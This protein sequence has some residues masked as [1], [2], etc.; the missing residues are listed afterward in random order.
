[1]SGDTCMLGSLLARN[2]D[3]SARVRTEEPGYFG[4]L[5]TRQSPDFFWIG[6]ASLFR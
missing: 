1:M 5:A 6:C 2:R 4:R 3:W